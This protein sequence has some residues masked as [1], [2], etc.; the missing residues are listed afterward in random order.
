MTDKEK[1]DEI[2]EHY[3]TSH[4]FPNDEELAAYSAAMQMAKWKE[5]QMIEKACEWLKKNLQNY[6]EDDWTSE[7]DF[8]E[9]FRKAV[10]E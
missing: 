2:S 4:Y 9:E 1:A 10:K 7:K 6:I 5:Q 3:A 8:I